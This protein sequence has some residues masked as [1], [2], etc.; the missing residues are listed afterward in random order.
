MSHDPKARKAA[1]PLT[2]AV[3]EAMRAQLDFTDRRDFENARR[4]HVAPVPDGGRI[5][6]ADR[7]AVWDLGAYDFLQGEDEIDT[8]NPSLLRLSRLNMANGLFKVVDRV[9]QGRGMDLANMT[10]IE[11]ETGLI[12]IDCLLTAQTAKAAL[13]LYYAHRP[14]VPVKALIYTHSH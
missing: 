4:G 1:E 9:W 6:R 12:L 7:P 14:R 11:G 10:I 5:G 2:R 8:I 13:E 3:H